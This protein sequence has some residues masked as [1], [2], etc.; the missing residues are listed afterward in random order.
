MEGLHG[1]L[2]KGSQP[3]HKLGSFHILLVHPPADSPAAPPLA[4]ARAAAFLAGSGLSLE[5]YD[6][7]LDF[8][9]NHFLTPQ[10]LT[11][12]VDL[13]E[14]MGKQGVFDEADSFSTSLFTNLAT[15][16]EQW[17]LKIAGVGRSLALLRTEDFYRPESCLTALKDIGDLLDLASLAY[18][19]S[20]IQWGRFS[21]PAVQDLSQ[22]RSFIEDYETNP[23]LSLCQDGL[24]SRIARARPGLIVLFVSAPDQVLAALTIARFCKKQRPMLHVALMGNHGL[25]AGTVGYGDSLLPEKDPQAL[26]DLIARL[27]GLTISGNSTNPDFSGLPMKDYLAPAVVLPIGEPSGFGQ[28]L[29]PPSRL[30][31]LLLEQERSLGA[32]G[33]LSKDEHLTPAYMAEMAGE[34]AGERPSFCIGLECAL[35][36]STGTEK[37][38]AAHKAGVRL[39]QWRDPA[40]ELN[41]L[42]TLLW[43]VSRAGIWNHV[44]IAAEQD[45]SLAQG[46][47]RFMAADPNIAHSWIQLQ[48]CASPFASP[49]D[50]AKKSSTAYTQVAE[51]PG[52]PLCQSLNEPV[53][54]L[55]Y[56]KRHGIKKVM[57]WRVRDDRCSV[58]SLGQNITYHFVIPH[59]L[60]PG[61]L[62]EIC[63][64]VEAGGSVG[65]KWVRYNLERAFLIAYVLE[66]GM[67][68]G[69][70]SL[71]YPRSEYVEAVNKQSGLDLT[72]YL[73]RGYTSVR[74]EYRGMGIGTRLLE[75]LTARVGKKKVFSIISSD[76]VATQKIALR[77][78]TKQVAT[79]YS[80]RLG[81]E[82]GVWIPA[83]MIEH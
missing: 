73:E 63:R 79:F 7:N 31:A 60:P 53:Y 45:N 52:Q 10:R 35:N 9:L 59:E 34:M 43:D 3:M 14:K 78:K 65:T 61:Y 36:A 69:N 29:T 24:A 55:L 46:L 2:A 67:I 17:A 18:Y 56:L 62:D 11:G 38:A 58:Y 81:K 66:E 26:L 64:M 28:N 48:P 23:F 27:T 51:L 6:A 16:S 15:N 30:M 77:N 76:N 82:I 75:G 21:N 42:T 1:D 20:R 74:P 5:Q 71:K 39:I 13:I 44:V 68:V 57:R 4:P 8:F 54:L 50:Q 22:V 25:L 49:A 32:E 40:G 37:L 33:F 83:W 41:F 19:P 70:S 47:I 72:K 12:F 80:E